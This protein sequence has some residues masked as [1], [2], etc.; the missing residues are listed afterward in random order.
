MNPFKAQNNN[1]LIGCRINDL[2]YETNFTQIMLY[3][4]PLHIDNIQSNVILHIDWIITWKI[5]FKK[6]INFTAKQIYCRRSDY[7][8]MTVDKVLNYVK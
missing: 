6:K 7:I 3:I 1:A 4:Y 2:Q 8:Q 5:S